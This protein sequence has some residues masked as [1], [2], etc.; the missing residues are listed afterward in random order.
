MD[1]ELWPLL[2]RAERHHAIDED[3]GGRADLR[4]TAD[5]AAMRDEVRVCMR[6]F[7]SE[8]EELRSALLTWG[9]AVWIGQAAA[10]AAILAALL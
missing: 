6:T 2:E 1:L 10:T 4:L 7:R 5:V 3:A 8:L 9:P